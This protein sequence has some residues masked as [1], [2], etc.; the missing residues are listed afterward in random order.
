MDAG[1]ANKPVKAG[2]DRFRGAHR[3][4]KDPDLDH[5]ARFPIVRFGGKARGDDDTG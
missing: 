4:D 3:T 5:I 2:L 1:T